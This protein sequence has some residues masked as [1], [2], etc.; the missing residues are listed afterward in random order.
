MYTFHYLRDICYTMHNRVIHLHILI[1]YYDVTMY[2]HILPLQKR[3]IKVQQC[4]VYLSAQ[5]VL[6]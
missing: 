3:K 1:E 5:P 2:T 4:R 6:L